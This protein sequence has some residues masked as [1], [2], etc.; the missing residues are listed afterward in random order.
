VTTLH[1]VPANYD[2]CV[3]WWAAVGGGV[4]RKKGRIHLEKKNNLI[5]EN[6]EVYRVEKKETSNRKKGGFSQAGI[7][8]GR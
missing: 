6:I 2:R 5:R 4:H 8:K 7:M 3:R 1:Y